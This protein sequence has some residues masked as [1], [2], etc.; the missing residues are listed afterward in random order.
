M[1]GKQVDLKVLVDAAIKNLVLHIV[2]NIIRMQNVQNFLANTEGLSDQEDVKMRHHVSLIVWGTKT[3]RSVRKWQDSM[4]EVCKK[5]PEDVL[6]NLPVRLIVR[7][8]NLI[9]S[10]NNMPVNMAEVGIKASKIKASS[11]TNEIRTNKILNTLTSS[12]PLINNRTK[13][14]LSTKIKL[15]SENFV[16]SLSLPTFVSFHLCNLGFGMFEG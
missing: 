13:S 11:K 14:K 1:P 12:I 3:I 10:A 16:T 15:V 5:V 4:A 8:I 9:R 7:Q 2:R 6:M